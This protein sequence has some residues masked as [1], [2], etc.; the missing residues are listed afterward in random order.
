MFAKSEDGEQKVAE[1]LAS[2]A[3]RGYHGLHD[4]EVPG[5][6]GNVGHILVGVATTGTSI[7]RG[8]RDLVAS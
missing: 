1:A 5:L 3:G 2:L 6:D 4:R 7:P 8:A